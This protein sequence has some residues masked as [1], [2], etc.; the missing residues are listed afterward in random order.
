MWYPHP[1]SY[2][3]IVVNV[4]EFNDRVLTLCLKHSSCLSYAQLL[5]VLI[6]LGCY[7][8]SA[9][10]ILTSWVSTVRPKRLSKE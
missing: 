10:R 2:D 5:I 6:K 3:N 8:Q 7:K 4:S 9:L 1:S